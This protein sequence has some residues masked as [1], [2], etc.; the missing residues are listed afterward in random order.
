MAL[1]SGPID[2]PVHVQSVMKVSMGKTALRFA[3]VR[4]E[5]AATS[6]LDSATALLDLSECSA[7]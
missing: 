1:Y 4:M 3:C 6:S 5:R 7:I 2:L